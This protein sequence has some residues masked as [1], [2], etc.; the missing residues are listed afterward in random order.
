MNKIIDKPSKRKR[1]ENPIAALGDWES[2]QASRDAGF[3]TTD[4]LVEDSEDSEEIDKKS[5]VKITDDMFEAA[6]LM[7]NGVAKI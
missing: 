6:K 3:K 4:K 7:K 2:K 1:V 5:K